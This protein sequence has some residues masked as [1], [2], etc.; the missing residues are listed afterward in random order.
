[1]KDNARLRK[2]ERRWRK[3]F[4][5]GPNTPGTD[6]AADPSANHKLVIPGKKERI[7]TSASEGEGSYI[8]MLE[9]LW[10]QLKIRFP[11]SD[12]QIEVLHNLHLAPTQLHPNDWAFPPDL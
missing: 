6:I 1:V 10:H 9:S 4:H 3:C 8:M 12:F 2:V 11:F 5:Y 7:C